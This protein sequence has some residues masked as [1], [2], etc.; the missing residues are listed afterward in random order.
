MHGYRFP[1]HERLAARIAAE[2]GFQQI[3][4]SH[5]TSPLMKLISR[6]DTTLADAYLSPILDHYIEQVRG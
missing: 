5:T 6:G 3:S 2:V 1:T 4:V